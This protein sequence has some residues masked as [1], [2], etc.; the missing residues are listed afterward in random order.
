MNRVSLAQG[1]FS[2]FGLPR[3]GFVVREIDW[4]PPDDLATVDLVDLYLEIEAAL[5]AESFVAERGAVIQL[6]NA[7]SGFGG[8]HI[9]LDLAWV[10]VTALGKRIL[11]M[12]GTAAPWIS[13][14][15]RAAPPGDGAGPHPMGARD[16]VVKIAGHDLYTIDL[17]DSDSPPK[18]GWIHAH[19]EDF[20]QF[21]DMVMVVA[22]SADGDPAGA[23]WAS[24][25]DGNLLIIEAEQTRWSAAM[26]LRRILTRCQRPILGAVL[27]GY[28]DH[29]PHWVGRLL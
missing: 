8:E 20:R 9:A 2:D 11:V 12:N 26:R 18:P 6:V 29:M 16:E 23:V 1:N 24:Q 10:A 25:V 5:S 27:H 19:M 28:R 22:P 7:S 3:H 14:A 15:K 17:H 21:F 4:I 13:R